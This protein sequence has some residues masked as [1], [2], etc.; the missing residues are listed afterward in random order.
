MM[1]NKPLLRRVSFALAGLRHA[2]Q[3]EKSL[4]FHG[5]AAGLVILLLLFLQPAVY[6]WAIVVITIALVIAAEMINSAIEGI[7]DFV[8]PEH[9]EKIKH[10]KD[11]A[12]GAVLI[13]SIS[14]MIVG[15]LLLFDT[16]L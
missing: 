10:I 15:L 9:D 2:F 3:C 14:A 6:W 5:V 7:C 11:M 13:M 12:A 4:R 1:K 16:F 8:Q